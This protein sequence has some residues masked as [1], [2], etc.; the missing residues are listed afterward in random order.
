VCGFWRRCGA[1]VIFV[2][3]SKPFCSAPVSSPEFDIFLARV[4]LRPFLVFF[5]SF[6]FFFVL[7]LSSGVSP[8]V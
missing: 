7:L 3:F 8:P 1:R 4:E 2:F 5:S 6:A